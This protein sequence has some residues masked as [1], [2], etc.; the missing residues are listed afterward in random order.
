MIVS[1]H[2]ALFTYQKTSAL[3]RAAIIIALSFNNGAAVAFFKL[4]SLAYSSRQI[5][6]VFFFNNTE[7]IV[8]L[9]YHVI[10]FAPLYIN[11]RCAADVSFGV[12]NRNGDTALRKNLALQVL[13][14]AHGTGEFIVQ[15]YI[16]QEI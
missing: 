12:S 11:S 14:I 8:V 9:H 5:L 3:L 16:Y 6:P 2:I 10:R 7:G 15:K 1:Y 13:H 4:D